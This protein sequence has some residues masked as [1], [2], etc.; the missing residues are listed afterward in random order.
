VGTRVHA[1]DQFVDEPAPLRREVGDD[2]IGGADD[3]CPFWFAR[4]CEASGD[5]ATPAEINVSERTRSRFNP[6]LTP[7]S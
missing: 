1:V 6:A 2:R 7:S 5:D 3:P 4:A